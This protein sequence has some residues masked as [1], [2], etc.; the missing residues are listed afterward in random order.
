MR[1]GNTLISS[2][3]FNIALILLSTQAVIQFC[4]KAYAVYA[5]QTE[6]QDIFG[7]EIEHLMGIKHLYA[8]NIFVYAFLSVTGLTLFYYSIRW[9]NV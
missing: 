6:I 4:S 8:D 1:V 2:F 3:V 5:E 9:P 7:N